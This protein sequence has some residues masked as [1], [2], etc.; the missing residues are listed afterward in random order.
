MSKMMENETQHK[1]IIFCQT[2][3]GVDDLERSLR[4]DVKL[5]DKIKFEVR[6]I[7]GDK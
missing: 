1:I 3:V 5:T 6:G 4:N 2:K 7:H